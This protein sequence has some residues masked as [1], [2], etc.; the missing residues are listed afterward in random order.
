[1]NADRKLLEKVI[2]HALSGKGAHVGIKTALDGLGWKLASVQPE[3]VSHSIFQLLNHN[4]LLGL[5]G[6]AMARQPETCHAEARSG[7]LA[8]QDGAA[9]CRRMARSTA[10]V[11]P[12]AAGNDTG[13]AGSRSSRE[14]GDKEP[15]EMLQTI[16]SHNS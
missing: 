14:A 5:V 9:D 4:G 11:R 6:G 1:M 3:G 7:R 15:L 10:P 2:Q 16:A 12:G 8:R 13:H